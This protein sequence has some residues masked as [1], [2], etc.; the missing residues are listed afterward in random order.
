MTQSCT[1][2][3]HSLCFSVWR[4]CLCWNNDDSDDTSLQEH[5]LT[6]RKGD[7]S[8]KEIKVNSTQYKEIGVVNEKEE[9]EE[10]EG[11]K[12]EID[13]AFDPD[14]EYFKNFSSLGTQTPDTSEQVRGMISINAVE[15]RFEEC[16][17]ML[18]GSG[19]D[20]LTPRE[21]DHKLK[22]YESDIRLVE[23]IEMRKTYIG[24]YEMHKSHFHRENQDDRVK[25]E[26]YLENAQNIRTAAH[27]RIEYYQTAIKFTNNLI[28]KE[29]INVEYKRYCYTLQRKK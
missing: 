3:M 21:V 6:H 2:K 26:F 28:D 11:G 14:E 15:D 27:D 25:A 13:S 7:E 16:E 4:C 12:G 5:E 19:I 10:E 22:R 18:T 8:K 9:E 20:E 24:R 29:R 17:R 23:D 1:E